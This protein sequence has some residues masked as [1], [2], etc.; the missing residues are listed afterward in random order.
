MKLKRFDFILFIQLK[1]ETEHLNGRIKHQPL[2][3]YNECNDKDQCFKTRKSFLGDCLKSSEQIVQKHQMQYL[4]NPSII[5][6]TQSL[7]YMDYPGNY[8]LYQNTTDQV[9]Y[10]FRL[11]PKRPILNLKR[12]R[13][14]LNSNIGLFR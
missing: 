14:N 11:F 13:K 10:L 3:L 12:S 2:I 7:N 1:A 6:T 9:I 4:R 8:E 5:Y